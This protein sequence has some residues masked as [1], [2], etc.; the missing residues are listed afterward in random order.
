MTV[1]I[2][3]TNANGTSSN[4]DLFGVALSGASR[5]TAHVRSDAT[6]TAATVVVQGS[7]D[8]STN[9]TPIVTFTGVNQG[10]A[11]AYGASGGYR[12]FRS[13]LSGYTGAG[14]VRVF[15]DA[16]YGAAATAAGPGVGAF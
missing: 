15:L 5:V 14:N 8:G 6:V 1:K 12:Y 10:S 4:T 7:I 13:V 2:H 11:V 3:D 9:W 16:Q